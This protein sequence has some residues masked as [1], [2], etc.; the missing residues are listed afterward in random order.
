MVCLKKLHDTLVQTIIFREHCRLCGCVNALRC[1]CVCVFCFWRAP[2][3]PLRL[4][5]EAAET[6]PVAVS[7]T[8]AQTPAAFTVTDL[9]RPLKSALPLSLQTQRLCASTNHLH[10]DVQKRFKRKKDRDTSLL[11]TSLCPL[12]LSTGKV[13]VVLYLCTK[14][15]AA[16]AW[17]LW[18]VGLI[19]CTGKVPR[20]CLCVQLLLKQPQASEILPWAEKW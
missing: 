9:C 19:D 16:L 10:T 1:E 14:K 7:N 15:Q 3:S 2:L 13:E 12:F 18:G 5:C 8:E 11:F 4:Y 17:A 20:V 6:L